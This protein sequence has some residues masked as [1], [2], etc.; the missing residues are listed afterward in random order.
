MDQGIGG[1]SYPT[2]LRVVNWC[3]AEVA[4]SGLPESLRMALDVLPNELTNIEALRLL[5]SMRWLAFLGRMGTATVV[6]T[7]F[8]GIQ[9]STM[10]LGARASCQASTPSGL[11]GGNDQTTDWTAKVLKAERLS[12]VSAP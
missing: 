1:H 6:V 9:E 5:A 4:A 8:G 3:R 7:G 10:F 11:H 12:T 2:S